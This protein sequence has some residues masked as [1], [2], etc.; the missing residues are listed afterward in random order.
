MRLP[1][2]KKGRPSAALRLSGDVAPERAQ[3]GDGATQVR[4]GHGSG[5]RLVG[6]AADAADDLGDL[7]GRFG[8]AR[9]EVFAIDRAGRA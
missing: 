4:T 1:R 8:E 6:R 2:V 9:D 7:A 5:L 3:H